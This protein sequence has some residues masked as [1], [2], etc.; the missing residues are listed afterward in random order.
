MERALKEGGS[1][2]DDVVELLYLIP[3]YSLIEDVRRAQLRWASDNPR[4]RAVTE[5]PGAQRRQ[6]REL[7]HSQL[8][9]K[10]GSYRVRRVGDFR[11]AFHL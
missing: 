8:R 10:L 6:R 3:D 11:S 2:P 9:V 1:A 5:A 4:Q 7:Y